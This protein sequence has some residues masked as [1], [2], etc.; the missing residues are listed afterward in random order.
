MALLSVCADTVFLD[1][2]FTDRIR[3][4]SEAGFA[5]DFWR[6]TERP[7]DEL[8]RMRDV[9][10]TSFVGWV[11]GSAL[12]PDG[13]ETFLDGCRRSLDVARRLGCQKLIVTTGE[14]D[15]R[16]VPV[17]AVAANPITRWMTAYAAY[18]R[19]AE[20]AAE[21]GVVYCLE[22]LNTKLDHPGYQL[23]TVADTSAVIRAVNH[24]NLRVL[25]D[26]YHAQVEEGNLVATIEAAADVIGLVQVADVPGRHEPGTGEIDYPRIA[27]ALSDAGYDGP[28]GLEAYPEGDSQVAIEQFRSAFTL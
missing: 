14:L 22:N 11:G 21:A 2:P 23:P 7:I 3:A 4:I 27:R 12:H 15:E 18:A 20:L 5:V 13:V 25:L 8:A 9:R 1:L 28:I 19:L 6:W 10:W 17:H 26:V 24:P 16:G